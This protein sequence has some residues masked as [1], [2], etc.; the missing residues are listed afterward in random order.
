MELKLA[1]RDEGGRTVVDIAGEIDVYTAPTL[2]EQLSE[3]VAAGKY[4]LV[5]DLDRSRSSTRPGS[6]CWWVA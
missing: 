6:A 3:L 4:D 1:T 5:L 2:R